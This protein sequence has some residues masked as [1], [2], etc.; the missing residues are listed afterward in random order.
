MN[1]NNAQDFI[2]NLPGYYYS[3]DS[4]LRYIDCNQNYANLLKVESIDLL[5]NY[6]DH[7][8]KSWA[9]ALNL[10]FKYDEQLVIAN[11]KP[12]THEYEIY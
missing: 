9:P 4:A 11:K 7:D 6:T 12:L 5:R 3:K 8:L 1:Q 2:K 10:R